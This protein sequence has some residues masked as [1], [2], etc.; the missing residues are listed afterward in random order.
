MKKEFYSYSYCFHFLSKCVDT[1][2]FIAQDVEE[3]AKSIGYDFSGVDMDETG[4]YGLRYTEFVIP[5]VK[6]V[7]E[8]NDYNN[9]LQTQNDRLQTQVDELSAIVR[10]LSGKAS[11]ANNFNET[12]GE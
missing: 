7:Q 5:L 9:R 12:G 11:N 2:Y 1:V 3:T 4:I 6:A 8:L 10:Q